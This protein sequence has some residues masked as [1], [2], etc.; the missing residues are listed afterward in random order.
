MLKEDGELI[1]NNDA[2]LVLNFEKN[3]IP[4]YI[5]EATFLEMFRS[6]DS[7]KKI[8]LYNPIPNNML[9]DEIEGMNPIVISGNL[10]L[11]Q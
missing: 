5:G 9:K 11:V 3:G 7:N 4:N 8:F 10:S 2:I 1:K 6:L